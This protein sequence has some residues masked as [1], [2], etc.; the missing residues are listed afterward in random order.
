MVSSG[1]SRPFP[2]VSVIAGRVKL[3]YAGNISQIIASDHTFST[4]QSTGYC[5]V[6]LMTLDGNFDVSQSSNMRG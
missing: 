1:K 4:D 5:A 6:E 2:R 3:I